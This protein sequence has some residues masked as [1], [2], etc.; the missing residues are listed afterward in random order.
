M[1]LDVLPHIG[2]SRRTKLD[3]HGRN[4]ALE[5]LKEAKNK[6]SKNKYD[7]GE[8][9]NVYE[10]VDEKEYS[11][12]VQRRQEDDWIIDD[13][14]FTLVFTTFAILSSLIVSLKCRTGSSISTLFSIWTSQ[15]S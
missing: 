9:D 15:E 2:R 1:E 10:E 12:R 11:K 4:A 5:K 13:G 6:G 8:V 14:K 3:R 7:I